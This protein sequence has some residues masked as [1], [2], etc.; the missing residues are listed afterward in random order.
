MA[1]AINYAWNKGSLLIAAS[2]NNANK[3]LISYP[4]SSSRVLAVGASDD[5]DQE[6]VFSNRSEAVVLLAP[7]HG[8]LGLDARPGHKGYRVASGT[9]AAAPHV[10]GVAGLI[11]SARPDL[12]NRQVWRTLW[13][14]T[15]EVSRQLPR[16]LNAY[17]ALNNIEFG[18]VPSPKAVC[19]H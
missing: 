12:T 2:G 6:A 18:G 17:K 16:R 19:S 10:S 1:R 7:G 3:R 4:A 13:L 5:R 11:W 9:S 8:I 14:N 15:D